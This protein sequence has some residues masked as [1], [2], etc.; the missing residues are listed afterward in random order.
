MLTLGIAIRQ[1]QWRDADWQVQALQQT[2]D[3]NQTNL[4]YYTNL[5]QNGLINDEIQNLNL[6][7]NALQTRTGAN[8][9]GAVGEVFHVIPDCFV[10]A[11]SSFIQAPT[12]TK[13]AGLFDTITKIMLTV[14]DIQSATA[15]IDATQAAWQRRSV[16]WFHQMQTLPIEIHQTELQI[17][18][19]QRRRDQALQELTINSGRSRT[20]RR[21][22]TSCA[23]NSPRRTF[24]YSCKKRP[25]RSTVRC[26]SWRI[27]R[28]TRLSA[29]SI[30]SAATPR[31]GS[32]PRK[33]GRTCTR[34]LLAGE[35]LDSRSGTWRRIIWTKM[36]GSTS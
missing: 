32:S 12:G 13:L 20:R 7:N 18:G 33:R 6:G 23:T 21:C 11:M 9:S 30:S 2:K 10:G 36:F 22:S 28:R 8:M 16:E 31:G 25:R 26:T 17:L 24:I 27:A 5:Y 1:D 35:R 29:R 15:S 14:A 19:A 4:L 3:V 34:G